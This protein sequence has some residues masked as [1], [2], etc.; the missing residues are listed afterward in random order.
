[1]ADEDLTQ[2][3][4]DIL[5][6]QREQL[7]LFRRLAEEQAR[8]VDAYAADSALYRQKLSEWRNKN[9]SWHW[10]DAFR[11]ITALGIVVLLG[12]LLFS[13]AHTH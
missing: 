1:M 11:V 8:Q 3:L 4:R 9:E 10:R 12:Y 5:S 2:I 13:G 7:D 6:A